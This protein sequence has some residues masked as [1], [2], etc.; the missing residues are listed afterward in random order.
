MRQWQRGYIVVERMAKL[1]IFFVAVGHFF[2]EVTVHAQPIDLP[3][4][5][6]TQTI[7]SAFTIPS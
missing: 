7:S 2:G 6:F 1:F 3:T 5:T 4:L